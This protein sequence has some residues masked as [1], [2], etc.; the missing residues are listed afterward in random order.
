MIVAGPGAGKTWIFRR[1]LEQ[2]PGNDE[3]R[4]VLTFINSLTDDLDRELGQLATVRTFHG[5]CFG[6]LKRDP[7]TRPGLRDDFLLQPHLPALI[8]EDWRCA[9]DSEA[10]NFVDG[11]RRLDS[12]VDQKF[13]L[14]RSNYY[15]AVGFDDAVYRVQR[16][17]N[18]DPSIVPA[19]DLVLIDEFQDF[20]PLEAEVIE[21]LGNAG[22]IVIAGDDDQ[23]LYGP[24]KHATWDYIRRLHSRGDFKVFELPFCMRCTEVIV[25]AANDIIGTAQSRGML[26]GRIA[27]RFEPYPPRKQADSAA[28]P[29][30]DHAQCSVQRLNANYFGRYIEQQVLAIPGEEVEEARNAN[31]APALV[32]GQ[33]QYLDQIE[34]HLAGAGVPVVRSQSSRSALSKEDGLQLLKQDPHSNLGWRIILATSEGRDTRAIIARSVLDGASIGSLLTEEYKREVLTEAAGFQAAALPESGSLP[35]ALYVRL[36]SFEGA[37]GLSAQHVFVVGLHDSDLPRNSSAITDREVCLFLVALT[38]AKKKCTF[39]T[40]SIFAQTWKAKSSFI[41]WI[42]PARLRLLEIRAQYWQS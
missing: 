24:L 17:W 10:P 28:Y 6:V 38:R 23:A 36:V 2:A 39:L 25:G 42:N 3:S 27:K 9:Y 34:K 14:E 35:S 15:N 16:A 18:D 30:I 19:L 13:F 11:M 8:E 5:Y 41:S 21:A 1:L 12:E 40:C 29:N 26:G 32:I 37:K 7:Q 22:P 4:L 31:D 20:N 33:S